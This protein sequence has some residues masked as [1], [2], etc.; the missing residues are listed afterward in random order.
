MKDAALDRVFSA[1]SSPKRRR[2]LDILQER[3]GITIADLAASFR[4][5]PVGVLKH[6]K[7]LEKAGLLI[8]RREGRVRRLYFN[9]VPIQLI[10]DRWTD[11]YS[12]F[13]TARMADLK[14]RLESPGARRAGTDGNPSVDSTDA[15]ESQVTSQTER[16]RRRA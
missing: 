16:T 4:M 8:T 2:M 11:R 9:A 7:L 10:Y 6:V 14:E 3:S 1:L 12:G 15:S 13:W 5:T